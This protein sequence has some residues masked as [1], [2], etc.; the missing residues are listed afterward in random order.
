LKNVSFPKSSILFQ[1]PFRTFEIKWTLLQY[2]H[3]IKNQDIIELTEFEADSS[4]KDIEGKTAEEISQ[5]VF[6]VR[7]KPIVKESKKIEPPKQKVEVP[8]EE[9]NVEEISQCVFHVNEKEKAIVKESKKIEVP[10]W[11]FPKQILI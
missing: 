6:Q 7:V 5:C 4:I 8:L 3:A 2:A 1:A 11:E 10:L 9:I